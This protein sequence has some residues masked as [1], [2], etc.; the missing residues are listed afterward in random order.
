V[1]TFS[2]LHALG[3]GTL[4]NP[5]HPQPGAA[6][7]G[8]HH[9]SVGPAFSSPTTRPRQTQDRKKC[10]LEI[11]LGSTCLYLVHFI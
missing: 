10:T 9:L 5:L 11:L 3:A 7:A 2:Q 6:G 4:R 1:A 8:A